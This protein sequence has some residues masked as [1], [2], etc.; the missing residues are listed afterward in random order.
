M[1]EQRRWSGWPVPSRD[2]TGGDASDWI[3]LSHVISIDLPRFAA[4]P[5]PEIRRVSSMPID[6]LNVTE[7][8][9]MCHVGTHIDAPIHFIPDGPSIAEIPLR[10]LC[11][12]GVV[13]HL[14]VDEDTLITAADLESASPRPRADDIVLID[15]GWWRRVH[16]EEYHRHPS[17]DHDAA[18]WLVDQGV[19][20]V[21][22]DFPTPDLPVVRR[23]DGFDW[24]IH[25]ILL[26][27]GTLI[28]EN[29]T[30]LAEITGHRVDVML[31]PL[32]ISGADGGPARVVA[33]RI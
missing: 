32:R 26:G 4:F 25:H 24:P 22:L 27:A 5:A 28:A 31:L 8:T 18:Q 21:G 23:P 20:L 13:L 3:E 30:N 14:D 12:P 7:M 17:L 33:R 16:S 2:V 11:G 9:I 10:R 19:K 15:T 29:L 1:C 6:P